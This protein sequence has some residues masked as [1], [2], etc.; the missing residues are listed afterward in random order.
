MSAAFFL[1]ARPPGHFSPTL[2]VLEP[3][4]GRRLRREPIAQRA[5]MAM[6]SIERSDLPGQLGILV[7]TGE[8][9][10]VADRVDFSGKQADGRGAIKRAAAM[11]TDGPG[12][13]PLGKVRTPCPVC[14]DEQPQ[15]RKSSAA[16]PQHAG[17]P[18]PLAEQ[19]FCPAYFP[20]Q[21]PTQIADDPADVAPVAHAGLG[22]CQGLPGIGE[23]RGDGL[24][25]DEELRVERE[26]RIPRMNVPENQGRGRP[27]P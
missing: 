3:R 11:L 21:L 4:T 23:R 17:Q 13:Q 24:G 20:F 8:D 1:S 27:D 19:S 25:R 18:S 5:P 14:R 12:S 6:R 26:L 7:S 9:H 15:R 10:P 2:G 16:H 22:V